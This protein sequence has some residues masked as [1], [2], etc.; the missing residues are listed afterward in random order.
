MIVSVS[1]RTDI[2]A[3]YTDWFM[4]RL[5]AGFCAVANPFNPRQA[6][7][8]PLRPE[9]V[10]VFVF[11]TKNARPL[12]P[13]LPR[14]S[15]L[16]YRFYFQYTVNGYGTPLE[17][18][19]PPLAECIR[20]FC[21]LAEAIGPEKVI[22]RYD[23]IILSNWTDRTY[24]RQKFRD[25]LGQLQTA[26][27][28]ITISLVDDYRQ[29]AARLRRLQPSGL[30]VDWIKEAG[31]V[32]GLMEFIAEAAAAKGIAVY[33]CAETLDL[34]PF[35]IKPGQCIDGQLIEKLFGIRVNAAKDRSQRKECGCIVSKDIGSY[36]SC[37]HGC[38]YCYAGGLYSK[39]M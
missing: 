21:E 32:A 3:F 31:E 5:E 18:G 15:R 34:G 16:G 17:P 33:S 14:L 7:H 25:I 11:W 35:G 13:H 23:P 10:T 29:A 30:E 8:V 6:S 20:T 4:E 2:P 19:V 28:R 27:Q 12:L 1:R 36:G 39:K 38:V 26:T 22:W 24:H 37:L 9:D